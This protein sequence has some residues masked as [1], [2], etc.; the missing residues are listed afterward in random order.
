MFVRGGY[1]YP[2]S[3]LYVS[4]YGGFYWSSV[5]YDSDVAYA[6]SFDPAD[7]SPSGG[8]ARYVGKSLR[9]VALGG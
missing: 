4:G 5:G 9:C 2:G 1:V 3:L 7:V 8:N 6:L